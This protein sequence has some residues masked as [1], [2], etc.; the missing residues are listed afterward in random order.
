MYSTT[1]HLIT[2][3]ILIGFG[4][5]SII[6]AIIP[7]TQEKIG[8]FSVDNWDRTTCQMGRFAAI[9]ILASELYR[10]FSTNIWEQYIILN[11]IFG[12]Y[13]MSY[14]IMIIIYLAVVF[15]PTPGL[16]NKQ[17]LRLIL[18]MTVLFFIH[19]ERIIIV[20]TS[21]HRDYLPSSWNMYESTFYEMLL[22]PLFKLPL[23]IFLLML[24]HKIIL[25]R[26]S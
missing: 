16:R 23:F 10:L 14:W 20:L 19:I 1:F 7:A 25:R 21:L 8:P 26:A 2:Q 13:A 12:P 5:F 18:G 6:Y 9:G 22:G 4:L 17:W 3:S 11:R 15:I 24:I